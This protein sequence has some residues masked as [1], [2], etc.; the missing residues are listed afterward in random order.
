MPRVAVALKTSTTEKRFPGQLK[1]DIEFTD[2]KQISIEFSI[3][4]KSDKNV[5]KFKR[6]FYA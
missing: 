6:L 5:F 1:F 3:L 4:N 2:K